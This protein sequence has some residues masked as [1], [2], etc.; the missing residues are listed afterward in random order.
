MVGAVE[1]PR[2][3][4]QDAARGVRQA[5]GDGHDVDLGP[6]AVEVPCVPLHEKEAEPRG[7]AVEGELVHP[8]VPLGD[9][10]QRQAVLVCTPHLLTSRQ[11]RNM[12]ERKKKKLSIGSRT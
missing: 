8:E 9:S 2:H 4:H 6:N 3:G 12:Q 11:A 5:E 10:R 1:G 7:G